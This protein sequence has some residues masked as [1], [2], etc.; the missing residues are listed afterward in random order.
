MDISRGL[1]E[2]TYARAFEDDLFSLVRQK[3]IDVHGTHGTRN[4]V[5]SDLVIRTPVSTGTRH[6]DD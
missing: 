5:I 6:R 3:G 2:G 1:P 4:R